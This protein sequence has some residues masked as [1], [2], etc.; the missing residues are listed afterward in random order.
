MNLTLK[1]LRIMG[2]T[3]KSIFEAIKAGGW[4]KI[5]YIIAAVVAWVLGFTPFGIPVGWGLIFIA[6]YV[7]TNTLWKYMLQG[8][9]K[10]L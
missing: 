3:P 2:T 5:G 9:N 8:W 4:T 10:K 7:N 1:N 6:V